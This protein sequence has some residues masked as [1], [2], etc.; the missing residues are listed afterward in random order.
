L[1]LKL[2]LD[3]DRETAD[4]IK[5]NWKSLKGRHFTGVM[6]DVIQ[7]YEDLYETSLP[8]GRE[9]RLDVEL[10]AKRALLW[11][12][13][14]SRP[15]DSGEYFMVQ[16]NLGPKSQKHPTAQIS[17]LCRNFLH[18]SENGRIVVSHSTVRDYLS[19]KLANR[20]GE[21]LAQVTTAEEAQK[22]IL[23]QAHQ[24]STQL[25]HRTIARECLKLLND[26]PSV[27]NDENGSHAEGDSSNPLLKYAARE[28]FKHIHACADDDGSVSDDLLDIMEKFFVPSNSDDPFYRWL[29]IFNPDHPQGR[30]SKNAEPL[31]YAVLLDFPD[32]IQFLL[33]NSASSNTGGGRMGHPLQLAC[34]KGQ[35]PVVTMML[36]AGA[37]V[38]V[39][40]DAIGTPLRAAI[41]GKHVD[42]VRKLLE[43]KADANARGGP[44]GN[45]LQIA[46][47][48]EE[49]LSQ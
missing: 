26:F 42:I 14:A 25:A 38:N 10:K 41:A 21:F 2:V 23:D 19:L 35:Q 31:Y 29:S 49:E 32:M 13:G 7:I 36:S 33:N 6:A 11:I 9:I 3:V 22:S 43:H 48:L 5:A 1:C 44:F 46:L 45:A 47:A 27:P 8:S 39:V 37:D 30:T 34:Y 24:D 15:L 18:L 40:D 12:F 16:E 17:K 4:E 28:W 20:V